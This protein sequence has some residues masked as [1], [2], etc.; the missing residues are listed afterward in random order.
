MAV[1]V[2]K[3][4]EVAVQMYGVAPCSGLGRGKVFFFYL[5]VFA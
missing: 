4:A 1:Q 2:Y 5:T 3:K